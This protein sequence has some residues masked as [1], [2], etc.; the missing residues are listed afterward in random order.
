MPETRYLTQLRQKLDAHFA[1]EE[2]ITLCFDLG[3]SFGAINAGLRVPL[4]L[5]R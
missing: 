2:L 4:G 5:I 3:E 1:E